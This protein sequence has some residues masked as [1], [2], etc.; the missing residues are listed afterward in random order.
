MASVFKKRGAATV[1]T[2]VVMIAATLAGVHFSVGRQ[3]AKIEQQFYDGVYLKKEGYTQTSIDSQLHQRVNAATG[4][5]SLAL[6][7]LNESDA[8]P[9]RDAYLALADAET[10]PEKSAANASLTRAAGD[11]WA[12]LQNA[13]M[14]ERDADGVSGYVYTMDA[15]QQVIDSSAYNEAVTEYMTKTMGAFPVSLIRHIAF[16]NYPAYF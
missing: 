12:R 13:G 4:L 16:C 2:V 5:Y 14:N 11:V 6:N 10:I 7:Y 3:S 9:L 15:A 8:A 1:I